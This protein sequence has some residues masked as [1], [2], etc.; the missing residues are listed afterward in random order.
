MASIVFKECFVITADP[1]I[2]QKF[3]PVSWF[4]SLFDMAVSGLVCPCCQFCL[5]WLVWALDPSRSKCGEGVRS[6]RAECKCGEGVRSGRAEWACG[7]R[8]WRVIAE[9]EGEVGMRSDKVRKKRKKKKKE[10]KKKK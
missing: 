7:V 10:E 2:R 4:G 5:F 3:W 6:G 8:V 1:S 9:W